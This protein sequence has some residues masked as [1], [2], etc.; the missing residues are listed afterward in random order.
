MQNSITLLQEIVDINTAQLT[1]PLSSSNEKT[2]CCLFCASGPLALSVSIDRGGYCPGESIA[3]ST[4]AE[5]HSNRRI[6]AV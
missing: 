6:T 3:I 5:N 2:L 4:A 1:A